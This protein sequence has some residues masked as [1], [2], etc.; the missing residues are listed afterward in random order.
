VE[1]AIKHY[2]PTHRFTA[3]EEALLIDLAL[4]SPSSFN[5]QH[6]RLV[7][8]KDSMV[9]SALRAAAFDQEQVTD[10]SLLY[11]ICADVK[12]WE[13]DAT[14]YWQ[15]APT[16]VQ[17]VLV[18]LTK[19]FY[20]GREQLQRDEAI[21]S[22]TF[23]AHT[24]MLTAKSMGYDSCPLIGF[25]ADEVAKIIGLPKDHVISIMLTVGKGV[26][27]AWPKP[28]QLDK[29]KVVFENGFPGNTRADITNLTE[30]EAGAGFWSFL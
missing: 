29:S 7:D 26:K 22:A 3:E 23:F 19:S 28:G 5:V 14:R 18:P 12:A 20:E 11:V 30:A 1:S 17:D 25:D 10:A 24:M 13:K 6:W 15:N 2:D 8:V 9:R 4:E 27:A 16:A 21:R